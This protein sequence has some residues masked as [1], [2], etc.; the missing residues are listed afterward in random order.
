MRYLFPQL[1]KPDSPSLPSVPLPKPSE[2]LGLLLRDT[3][4]EA[5]ETRESPLPEVGVPRLTDAILRSSP[6]GRVHRCGLVRAKLSIVVGS[7][8]SPT[9]LAY[10]ECVAYRDSRESS[11]THIY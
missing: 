6:A 5:Q 3:A 2:R 4:P 9:G 1:D 10:S 8:A 7:G 11:P